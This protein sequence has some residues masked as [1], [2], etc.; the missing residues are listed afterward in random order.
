MTDDEWIRKMADL[1][2]N[3]DVS[4]GT[5]EVVREEFIRRLVAGGSSQTEAEHEWD[6]IQADEEGNL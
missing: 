2:D 3:Y 5:R 6:T 4:V 1:E